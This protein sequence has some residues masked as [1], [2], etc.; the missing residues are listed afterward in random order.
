MTPI[1]FFFSNKTNVNNLE[2]NN[3]PDFNEFLLNSH[4]I[5][6]KLAVLLL[7]VSVIDPFDLWSKFSTQF[8]SQG[9]FQS[10][11]CFDNIF[12]IKKFK[13]GLKS[14]VL[15]NL[16][17]KKICENLRKLKVKV[18]SILENQ[19]RNCRVSLEFSQNNQLKNPRMIDHHSVGECRLLFRI[20]SR[21]MKTKYY[22]P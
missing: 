9:S 8:I 22:F 3:L 19:I 4:P 12:S 21:T 20:T 18:F 11:Q 13:F 15:E 1:F 10:S 6:S 16:K 17:F 5:V 14:L 7:W 2:T